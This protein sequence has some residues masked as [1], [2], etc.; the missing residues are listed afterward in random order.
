MRACA[1]IGTATDLDTKEHFARVDQALGNDWSVKLNVSR[2]EQNVSYKYGLV[3]G[4]VNPITGAG[5]TLKG[6]MGDQASTQTAADLTLNG[7]FD[8]FGHAQVLVVGGNYSKV[9]GGGLKSY[10]TLIGANDPSLVPGRPAGNPAVNV[11]D[12]NPGDP[13]YAERASKPLS[14]LYPDYGTSQ[15][16][17]YANLRLTFWDP[18]H[19]NVGLRYSNYGST[20]T[21][22]I[23]CNNPAAAN[24]Q[25]LRV[26]DVTSSSVQKHSTHD[27]SPPSYS[28]VYDISKTLSAY[29]SYTSIYQEQSTSLDTSG[30]PLDPNTGSNVEAGLKWSGRNGRINATLSA[31]RLKQDNFGFTCRAILC[32]AQRSTAYMSAVT[33]SPT[34]PT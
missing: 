1:S 14:A 31:Y 25:G 27:L 19:L 8:L 11:F 30:N 16:G 26:G 18:L 29:G 15:W 10:A 3:T 6:S 20:Y 34:A 7:S 4:T 9:D 12:F 32:P 5:P 28:L 33:S 23:F 2:T 13:A 24:C 22:Q 17:A 21:Q